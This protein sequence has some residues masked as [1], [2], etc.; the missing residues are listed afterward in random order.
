MAAPA[1]RPPGPAVRARVTR[2]R[3]ACSAPARAPASAPGDARRGPARA[4]RVGRHRARG[5]G[6][7]RC[8]TACRVQ[9]AALAYLAVIS[10]YGVRRAG[11][12]RRRAGL[13]DRR[14][15]D[16]GARAAAGHARRA[17][18]GHGRRDE[19][20]GARRRRARRRGA[21][22]DRDEGT[23]GI[24]AAAVIEATGD[25]DALAAAVAAARPGGTVVLLGSPRGV[26][27]AAPLG[28][29]QRK[30]LRVVGAHISALATEARRRAAIPS[31]RSRART[32]TALAAGRLDVAD[33]A[34]EAVDPREIGLAYRRLARGELGAAHLDW[35][36]VPRAER[37]A[38]RRAWPRHRRGAAGAPALPA[39]AA[40]RA[41]APA[42]PLRFARASAAATSGSRTRARSRPPTAPSSPSPTTSRP[43]LAEAVAAR[44]GG[45]G[46]GLARRGARS[47][48]GRRRASSPC[49]TTCMRRSSRRPPR[50]A[51]TSSSRSRSRPTSPARER[52]RRGGGRRGRRAVVCFSFRYD[53]GDAGRRARLVAGRR[54]R[55]RC[56]ARPS[57]FHTDKPESYWLGGF[58]GRAASDWRASRARA[59]GGVL[60][61]NL[62]HYV[63]LMRYVA[64]AELGVGR[65]HARAPTPAPRSR[66]RSRSRS[67][68]AAARSG[69]SS[70]SASTRGAPRDRA[71]SSGASRHARS[72]P[73]RR[74]TPSARSAASRPGRWCRLAPEAAA[75]ERRVFVE[76]FARGD[77]RRPP[78]GRYGRRRARGAGVRRRRLPRGRERAARRAG[79]ATRRRERDERARREAAVA[80]L[81]AGVAAVEVDR[82]RRA[83]SGAARAARDARRGRHAAPAGRRSTRRATRPR[84]RT[85]LGASRI[86]ARSCSPAAPRRRPRSTSTPTCTSAG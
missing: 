18:R 45:D 46:G 54:A 62:T 86:S 25:P 35:T 84:S 68:S 77:R 49:R 2:P 53:A 29:I 6:G 34:G 56:V 75:D 1:Q 78:A 65:G 50:P 26:T 9:D 85:L 40:H 30:G 61:M 27:P 47:R 33:L 69:R 79:A 11:P 38:A 43:Q 51:C 42:A 55:R 66:T 7:R 58:S 70:G 20:R 82:R 81:P 14:R 80:A 15:A 41:G 13:R 4:P 3:A 8:P 48:P 57:L 19:P 31:R 76:R 17:R 74:S 16:R 32:S 63:D 60:I 64:G 72:S 39:P 83:R 71:S 73:S 21:L 22:R 5:V 67:A 23:A 52:D 28:E 44:F 37:A 59:G 10:G 24:E 36:R 12:D